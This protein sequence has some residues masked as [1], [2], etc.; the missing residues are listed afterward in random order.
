MSLTLG[1]LFSNVLLQPAWLRT[2][3]L[4]L[5]V[6][7]IIL[8]LSQCAQPMWMDVLSSSAPTVRSISY[9]RTRTH[10]VKSKHLIEMPNAQILRRNLCSPHLQEPRISTPRS[11]IYS[12][13]TNAE[14]KP[15]SSAGLFFVWR[16]TTGMPVFMFCFLTGKSLY[17]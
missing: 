9:P 2:A 13:F 16:V 4:L 7:F 11:G 17:C 15:S 12:G 10:L 3:M 1:Q 6:L 8:W 5:R 14:R